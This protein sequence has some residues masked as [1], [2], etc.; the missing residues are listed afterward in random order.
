[1]RR[2]RSVRN[3]GEAVLSDTVSFRVRFSEVDSMKIVWHG[4]YVRYFED[5]RE[6]FGRR[7]PGIGYMDIYQSGYT[8]PIVDLQLQYLRPLTVG[9]TAT[10]EIRYIDTPAAKICFEYTIR[11]DSDGEVAARGS[12]MQVFVD[13]DG[14]LSLTVPPFLTQWRERWLKK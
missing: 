12:S 13:T 9:D 8:A 4:E 7:Y 14:E 1:M 2:N 11:R 3:R 10:V 6:A 5:A